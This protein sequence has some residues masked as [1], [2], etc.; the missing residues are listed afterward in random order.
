MGQK[1]SFGFIPTG[2]LLLTNF[3]AKYSRQIYFIYFTIIII[4]DLVP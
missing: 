4:D 1:L 2:T 3:I